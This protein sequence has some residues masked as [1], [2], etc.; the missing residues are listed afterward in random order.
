VRFMARSCSWC[1]RASFRET[2]MTLSSLGP[3]SRRH[4]HQCRR[5]PCIVVHL[6]VSGKARPH[7]RRRA[8]AT[9]I[10]PQVVQA[11]EFRR[12]RQEWYRWYRYHHIEWLFKRALI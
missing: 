11:A 5:W 3:Q 7:P 8:D 9:L 12:K 6:A 1:R 2:P 10:A 4:S